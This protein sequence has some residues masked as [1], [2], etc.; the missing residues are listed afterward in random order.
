LAR[1]LRLIENTEGSLAAYRKA[2]ALSPGDSEII[3]GYAVALAY[4]GDLEGA[5]NAYREAIRLDPD[6][7][8]A[9]FNLGLT[10]EIIG[11]TTGAIRA[12]EQGLRVMPDEEEMTR[13]L[14]RLRGW[15]SARP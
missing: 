10:L 2:M 7:V 14:A 3:F 8:D 6:Y 11:D 9:Y 4:K 15:Q 13:H 12:Y 5:V 1:T